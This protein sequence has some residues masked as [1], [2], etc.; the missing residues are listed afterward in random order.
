MGPTSSKNPRDRRQRSR[1]GREPRE[2]GTKTKKETCHPACR[3][4]RARG[5]GPVVSLPAPMLGIVLACSPRGHVSGLHRDHRWT[6]SPPP[7][8]LGR[9]S[10]T[11]G[12]ISTSEG[13]AYGNRQTWGCLERTIPLKAWRAGLEG[14]PSG[15]GCAVQRP[16]ENTH[17]TTPA[18]LFECSQYRSYL[19]IQ[20]VIVSILCLSFSVHVAAQS[21]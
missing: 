18:V 10:I 5:G 15:A 7:D 14:K 2:K 3:W 21:Q 11:N 17:V 1:S 19:G 16:I 20:I 13:M 4:S 12:I 9:K 8:E 6:T